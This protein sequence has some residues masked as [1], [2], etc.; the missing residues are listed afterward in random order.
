MMIIC[1]A[2]TKDCV[3][4]INAE[5]IQSKEDLVLSLSF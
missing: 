3:S 5:F 4:I 1:R 2:V